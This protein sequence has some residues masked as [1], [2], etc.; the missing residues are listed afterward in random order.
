MCAHVR[1]CVQDTIDEQTGRRVR[2]ARQVAASAIAEHARWVQHNPYRLTEDGKGADGA[3]AA[4]GRAGGEPGGNAD[5]EGDGEGEE[6]DW[7]ANGSRGATNGVAT[8]GAATNGAWRT[9]SKSSRRSGGEDGDDDDAYGTPLAALNVVLHFDHANRELLVIY[10]LT[11]GGVSFHRF[12][13]VGICE[14]WPT[15]VL[16]CR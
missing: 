13:V 1:C 4:N 8:N 10:A 14:W 6:M 11:S 7:E 9:K 12:K 3:D 15:C 16:L 5:A 2:K